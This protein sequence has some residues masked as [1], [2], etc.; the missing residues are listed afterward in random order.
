LLNAKPLTNGPDDAKLWVLSENPK[1]RTWIFDLIRRFG[2]IRIFKL[3][4]IENVAPENG[5]LPPSRVRLSPI[6]EVLPNK[7]PSNGIGGKAV[8]LSHPKRKENSRQHL[9]RSRP[10]VNHE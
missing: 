6:K 1:G 8:T 2:E 10:E 9:R 5:R 3:A 4:I 7:L